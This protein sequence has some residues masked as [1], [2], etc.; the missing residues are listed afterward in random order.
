[1]LQ[2]ST[3]EAIQMIE[4]TVASAT[5]LARSSLGFSTMRFIKMKQIK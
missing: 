1:V 4:T 2:N 3:A 5:T